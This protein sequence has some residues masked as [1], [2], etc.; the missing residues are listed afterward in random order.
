MPERL[1]TAFHKN[2][3][4]GTP[5]ISTTCRPSQILLFIRTSGQVHRESQ[6]HV[7]QVIIL[8]F[9]K[10]SGQAHRESQWHVGRVKILLFMKTSGQAHRKSQWHISRIQYCFIPKPRA[11]YNYNLLSMSSGR[12]QTYTSDNDRSRLRPFHSPTPNHDT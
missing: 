5:R 3:G 2:I 10:T 9:I 7:G 11:R 8:L 12:L 1:N 6:W 4:P